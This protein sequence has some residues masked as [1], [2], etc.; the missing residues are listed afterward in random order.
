MYE[1]NGEQ[2]FVM[3]SH[4]HFWDA[5]PE[6]WV[7]GQEQ[8]A[9]GWIECFHAYMSLAPEETHWPIE[10]FRKYSEE[11]FVKDVFEDGHVDVGVFQSTYLKSVVQRGLQH[12]RAQ[13]PAGRE[14]SGQADRQRPLGPARRATPASGSLR[15]TRSATTSRG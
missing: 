3:D 5:S 13:R 14:V 12:R 1:H 4:L 10:K 9:E 7:K 15:R 11:D 8:Y 2:Y 6:N